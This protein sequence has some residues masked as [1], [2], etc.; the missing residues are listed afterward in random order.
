MQ[1][2]KN[3]LWPAILL[4]ATSVGFAREPKTITQS[5]PSSVTNVAFAR[6]QSVGSRGSS[7]EG[8]RCYRVCRS[9]RCWYIC[10]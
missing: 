8:L 1:I 3:I 6:D 4:M 10:N 2:L 7:A 5:T 9:G